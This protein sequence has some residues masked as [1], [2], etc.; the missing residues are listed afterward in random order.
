MFII[1]NC[2]TLCKVCHRRKAAQPCLKVHQFVVD[3]VNVNVSPQNVI[4]ATNSFDDVAVKAIKLL[5][6]R[7]LLPYLQ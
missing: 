6:K 5:E 4:V 3:L 2:V 7:Q 1:F